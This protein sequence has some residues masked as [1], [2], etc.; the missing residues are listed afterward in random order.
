MLVL[1]VMLVHR[2]AFVFNLP[3]KVRVA[4]TGIVRRRADYGLGSAIGYPLL[5][6]D[7][8]Q[9]ARKQLKSIVHR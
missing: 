5:L 4:A 3:R 7:W 2:V 1:Q 9:T 6:P 8:Q